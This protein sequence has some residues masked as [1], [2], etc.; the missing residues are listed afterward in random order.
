MF[1]WFRNLMQ[2]VVRP[3]HWYRE[4]RIQPTKILC[5]FPQLHQRVVWTCTQKPLLK[6]HLNSKFAHVTKSGHYR[7]SRSVIA[8]HKSV[9][10]RDDS[11]SRRYLRRLCRSSEALRPRP[12]N[13]AA[14]APGHHGNREPASRCRVVSSCW[15]SKDTR[16]WGVVQKREGFKKRETWPRK[17]V[18]RLQLPHPSSA[19]VI[20]CSSFISCTQS[21]EP[22]DENTILRC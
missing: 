4:Q 8:Q 3:Y 6:T 2:V 18:W 7:Y 5:T 21:M 15:H 14:P 17:E 16:S 11:H 9:F 22:L 13:K 10:M 1:H 12:P 19:P 20:M